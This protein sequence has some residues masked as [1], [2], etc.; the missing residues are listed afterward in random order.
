MFAT[1]S[2]SAATQRSVLG[3]RRVAPRATRATSAVPALGRRDGRSAVVSV[4][5]EFSVSKLTSVL[6]KK[7][8][9]DLDRVFKGTSKTRDRLS[10]M[11]E[12]LAL[13]RLDDLEDTLDELEETLL[14]VDFGPATS[15]KVLDEIRERVEKG[16][17]KT[18]AEVKAGLKTAIVNI[19]TRANGGKS[20]PASLTL[21]ETAGEPSVVLVVGV[22]GGGKTTTVGKLSHR[23]ASESGAKVMLVPGDTFRAAAAEQLATWAER[24]AGVMA[25]YK[26]GTKPGALCYQAVDEALAMGDVDVV[27]ADTSGRL[28]TNC[29]LMDELVGVKKSI[30]KRMSNAPHETLLVLDGTTGLNMLNQARE[31]HAAVD[32][33][34]LI[35]TKLDGTARGGAVVSVVDELEIPVKF[36]G[37]GEGMEDLQTFEP[38]SFVDALFPEDE[39]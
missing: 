22:N 7:T 33:G 36:V 24:S 37:V 23:F 31:F 13:W 21:N 26:E 6:A 2:A 16:E 14:S 1:T 10:Y 35:L 3:G 32:V 17:I 29:D 34:G 39:A 15:A 4:R 27:L 18:G 20:G 12:V 11:D 9:S 28:H 19:L 25:S 38:V 5:A 30:G 8:Q